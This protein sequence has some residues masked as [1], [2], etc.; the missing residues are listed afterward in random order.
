MSSRSASLLSRWGGLA[1]VAG[2]MAA[3]LAAPGAVAA[4]AI[5]EGKGQFA[6]RDAKGHGGRDLTVYTYRP[7]RCD[8]RCPIQIVLH[9]V[10]RNASG[11]RDYWSEAAERHGFVVVA[12]L[13][14]RDSWGG[15]SAYNRG[16]VEA[17]DDR[18]RWAFAVIEHL[19]DE[20]ADGR[21]DYRLFG[22]SAGAQ[23][24]HRFLYFVPDNRASQAIAA[25]AGWYTLPEWRKARAAHPWPHSL[26]DAKVGE[27][28]A[29]RALGQPLTILLGE[30]DTD[31]N[32]SDLDRQPGSLAQGAQ[33]RARGKQFHR[34]AA[35]HAPAQG[36]CLW[37]FSHLANCCPGPTPVAQ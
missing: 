18:S 28:E 20:I 21:K 6:F 24:V 2:L 29:R 22:H 36:A 14:S 13:F 30:S 35:A 34:V 33:R 25:N 1:M 10:S 5:P 3:A 31:P 19:F 7:S 37:I 16:G 17:T 9:G 11:Y 26:V 4:I 15:A 27:R 12:P 23:F 32:A 8:A